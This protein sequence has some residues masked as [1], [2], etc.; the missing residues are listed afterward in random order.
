MDKEA[1]SEDDDDEEVVE[2]LKLVEQARSESENSPVA[3]PEPEAPLPEETP[4]PKKYRFG[5]KQ[6]GKREPIQVLIREA[7][8]EPISPYIS[9]AAILTALFVVYTAIAVAL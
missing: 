4:A 1:K 8:K 5:L 9:V 2:F 7:Q 6:K 3:Y